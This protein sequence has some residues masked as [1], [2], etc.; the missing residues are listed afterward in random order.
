MVRLSAPAVGAV[1]APKVQLEPGTLWTAHHAL[2]PRPQIVG[3]HRSRLE[4]PL[5][6]Q[7]V[8]QRRVGAHDAL[9]L[10][11]HDV[12]ATH[13]REEKYISFAP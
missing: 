5:L 8:K 12:L 9:I 7:V 6:F 10:L 11:L 1:F 4:R 3:N 13:H 2:G